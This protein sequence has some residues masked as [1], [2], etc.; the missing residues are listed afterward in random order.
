[1]AVRVIRTLEIC[2]FKSETR[3]SFL[4]WTQRFRFGDRIEAVCYG[5]FNP[6]AQSACALQ[7]GFLCLS[8]RGKDEREYT[9]LVRRIREI[10]LIGP[11]E[12]PRCYRGGKNYGE[13][14]YH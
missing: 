10:S 3:E 9:R 4:L 12:R 11:L 13:L 7:T 6:V 5:R 8:N 14:N 1:M 2:C